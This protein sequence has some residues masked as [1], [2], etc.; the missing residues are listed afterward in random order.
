MS[1]YSGLRVAKYL[2]DNKIKTVMNNKWYSIPKK[3]AAY[4]KVYWGCITAKT[5]TLNSWYKLVMRLNF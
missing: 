1:G 5:Y 3:N 4:L 2:E